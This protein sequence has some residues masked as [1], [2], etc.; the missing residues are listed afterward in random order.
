MKRT[1]DSR[2]CNLG[3]RAYQE[4]A[5]EDPR[6]SFWDVAFTIRTLKPPFQIGTPSPPSVSFNG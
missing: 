5:V 4:S 1:L 3:P 2:L 6:L